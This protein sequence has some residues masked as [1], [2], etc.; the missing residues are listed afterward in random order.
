MPK[1][2]RL[3]RL[4]CQW[5]RPVLLVNELDLNWPSWIEFEWSL[6]IHLLRQCAYRNNSTN[7][8]ATQTYDSLNISQA[9]LFWLDEFSSARP[10]YKLCLA[11]LTPI[12][13]VLLHSIFSNVICNFNWC[14]TYFRGSFPAFRLTEIDT[15]IQVNYGWWVREKNLQRNSSSF[16]QGEQ[17]M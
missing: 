4:E 6:A 3:T 5:N 16:G 15:E 17:L 8:L 7:A 14:R 10:T 9:T 2:L 13:S 12:H 11:G 1:K